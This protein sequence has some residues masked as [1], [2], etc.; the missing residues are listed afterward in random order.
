MTQK[1]TFEVSDE[2]Y[3][4]ATTVFEWGD[5]SRLLRIILTKLINALEKHGPIMVGAILSEE[6]E[7]TYTPNVS[8]VQTLNTTGKGKKK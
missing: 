1:L 6:F 3:Q 5:R 8:D 2:L 4:R 7:F